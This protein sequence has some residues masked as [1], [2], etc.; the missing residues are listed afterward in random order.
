MLTLDLM[1]SRNWNL[2]KKNGL[3]ANFTKAE[4]TLSRVLQDW[5]KL[6]EATIIYW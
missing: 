1:I 5:E 6:L 2:I 3:K 4:T